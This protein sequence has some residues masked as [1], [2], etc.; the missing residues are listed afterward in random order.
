VAEALE[1]KYARLEVLTVEESAEG[2]PGLQAN[3]DT[4]IPTLHHAGIFMLFFWTFFL[5][6]SGGVGLLPISEPQP[7]EAGVEATSS[8]FCQE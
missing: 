3:H 6:E 8:E 2:C 1:G 7:I 5:S 4:A